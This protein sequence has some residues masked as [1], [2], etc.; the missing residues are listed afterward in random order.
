MSSYIGS[1]GLSYLWGKIKAAFATKDELSAKPTARIYYGTCSTTANTY[2]KSATV[3]TFPLDANN[4][5][6]AGICVGIKYSVT[7][8]YKTEGHTYTLNV[9]NTGD[10]PMYYNNAELATSTSANTLV[11]GYK[12]RYTFYMFNG[13][14]WVWLNAS[15]DTNSTYSAMTQAEI[16]AG[17]ST[18]GRTM[19]PARLRDN[20]YTEG[21]VDTLLSAKYALPSGGIPSTDLDSSVQTSLGLADTALQSFTETDPV[22]SASTAASISSSD[23]TNWN[24]KT[25]NV[26]TVTGVKMNGTTNS[27]TSGVVD[28]GTVITSETSLSKGTTSGNGNAVTDISVSGH[29]ITLTK[30][31]TFLTSESDP[32]YTASAA[33]DYVSS[34]E[35]VTTLTGGTN[36]VEVKNA[37]GTGKMTITSNGQISFTTPTGN[38]LQVNSANVVTDSAILKTTSVGYEQAWAAGD[39]TVVPTVAV[40]KSKLVEKSSTSGLLKNDGTVDTNTY[41]T[42]H[43]DISGKADKVT[44]ATNGNFAALDSNGNLTDSGHKHSDYITSHQDITGKADK[45]TSATNGNF[46]G[47]DSNGNLTDSGHKHSDYQ[48]ALSTQTAYTSKGSATKVPQI[49]TNTL[50]QVTGITEVTITQPDISNCVQKSNTAGLLKND[51]TVDTSTYVTASTAPVT[52]VNSQTGAVSLTIPTITFRTWS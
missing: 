23:I 11:A 48:T 19:T 40:V 51:G 38:S 6:L 44:S 4:K 24:S 1:T 18:T 37:A 34:V 15:Y 46:A 17:T 30:G 39:N 16:D 9:N 12:N 26:G 14:Q 25:D 29:E 33:H 42:S 13:T 32:V 45:V 41:L 49:T 7:N 27:P 28:L 43:Q 31:S 2:A 36:G 21:E 22:F 50:G 20:F 5:P 8:T 10:F 52:S 47:L 3:E 35:L